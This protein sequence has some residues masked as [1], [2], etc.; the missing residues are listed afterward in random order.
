MGL[1]RALGR[2]GSLAVA[3][4]AGAYLL[5]RRGLTTAQAPQL[6]AP[7]APV[8]EP[9]FVS[10]ADQPDEGELEAVEVEEAPVEE[11][12]TVEWDGAEVEEAAGEVI[13]PPPQGEE[14]LDVTA[15]V[16]DLLGDREGAVTDAEVVQPSD[17][18]RLAEQ[19]RIALAEEPGLLTAPVDIEVD[20]GYVT[21]RG[22]LSRPERIIAVERQV[23]ALAG[24]RSL[25]S[26][27]Q[28]GGTW[29]PQD[30]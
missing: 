25:E 11:V 12:E 9:L 22:E 15:V 20:G 19:I 17:D 18:A 24:V 13:A 3:G 5:R 8:S 6:Q 26:Y 1:M 21:L 4:A 28:L 2:A 16:D 30:R 23:E 10:Q 27:L 7:T 29:P 14:M